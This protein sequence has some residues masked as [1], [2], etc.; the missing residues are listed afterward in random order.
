MQ[1]V[2]Y[3]AGVSVTSGATL[4]ID[5][6]AIGAEALTWTVRVWGV[7]ALTGTGTGSLSEL[8]I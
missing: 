4:D 1:A 3:E 8:L 7:G 5:G 6:V 2:R